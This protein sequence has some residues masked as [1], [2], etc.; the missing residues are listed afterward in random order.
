VAAY[1]EA[2]SNVRVR[3][4]RDRLY[5]PILVATAVVGVTIA[6][7]A[8]IAFFRLV[9]TGTARDWIPVYQ[10]VLKT[11]FGALAVGALGGLAKLIFDQ[12]KAQEAAE[13]ELRDLRYGFISA[14]VEVSH[15]I[16]TARTVI[17][18]NRSVKSWTDIVNDRIIPAQSRLRDMTHELQNWADAESRVFDDTENVIKELKEMNNY[19]RDLVDEYEDKKQ[20]LGELQRKAEEAGRTN[21]KEREHLL[22]QIW[23]G[24]KELDFLGDLIKPR[25]STGYVAYQNHYDDALWTMRLSLA[26]KK[27][28]QSKVTASSAQ[29][30]TTPSS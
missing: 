28:V 16:D 3:A 17:R 27:A 22:A 19:L 13:T 21:Q 10:D 9:S 29:G 8:V 23:N 26:P 1:H 4:K 2:S 12:R 5:G 7:I 18:A 30:V 11:S 15:D 24:M 25:R 14:L 6:A 20:A